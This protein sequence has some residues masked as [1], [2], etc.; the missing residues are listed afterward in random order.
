[1]NSLATPINTPRARLK[2]AKPFAILLAM[3]VRRSIAAIL[4]TLA[5]LLLAS[6]AGGPPSP[7]RKPGAQQSA[8]QAFASGNYEQA[9]R[10]WQRD[11]LSA[12]GAEAGS[13]R[14]SAADAWLLAGEEQ[15][16]R[17]NLRWVEKSALGP[18]DRARLNLVLADLALRA[19]HPEEAEALL[20]EASSTL[21]DSARMRYE[22]LSAATAQ[23]LAHP[24]ARDLR[25]AIALIEGSTA[26]QPEQ[27]VALLRA[28]ENVPSQELA[29]QANQEGANKETTGWLDLASVIRQNLVQ[30]EPL[31]DA[32]AA[33]KGRHAD[34]TLSENDAL[35][36]WLRYRQEFSPPLKVAVLLPG[37]G[38]FQP[39]GE[40]LRDGI[41][42]AYFDQPGGADITF[43][44]T[45]EE[46]E[47]TAAAYF[48]A[49]EQGAQW[50]I[51]P[52]QKES[53]DIL[54]NL[55]GLDTPVLALN[56]L[57]VDFVAPAGLAGQVLGISLSPEEEARAVA[58]EAMSAGLQRAIILAPE[59]EW[60]ERM[61]RNFEAE[62]LRENGR[63]VAASRYAETEND[64]STILQRLLKI[65]ESTARAQSVQNT[66]GAEVEFEP[67]RR[68]DVDV[69]F[70]AAN[71]TQGR[72]MRP[73]LRFHEA[74]DIPVYA[75][76]RVF[77]GKP[78][79]ASDQD[80]NGVNFPTTPYQL[81]PGNDDA[82]SRYSSLRGGTFTSLFALGRDA[83][84]L[85]PWLGLMKRDPDFH[86]PG[87]AG[88][89]R[90][91]PD[92]RL[93]REPQF[94]VFVGGAPTPLQRPKATE[95]EV[96]SEGR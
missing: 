79:R 76:G 69:I 75:T 62:F 21:P 55:A 85:L 42:S 80:L 5:T 65:D 78:D 20:K 87:A 51:G 37:G 25:E 58:R 35:D 1:M 68:N 82:S 72:L 63:I 92:N 73:Q 39:A 93:L 67:I 29:R 14:I 50:I 66:L 54:L 52:L 8:E 88:D 57:P 91:G 12:S 9:A 53:I 64:Y 41:M 43:H 36:L 70:L 49:R 38:R 6:C 18:A 48:E 24:G 95:T 83:W 46:G 10:L 86:F 7:D 30:P 90:N 84:N 27:A 81:Q 96:G 47:R 89:Y 61:A 59:S 16:A 11:A 74:G 31:T 45:G 94:A 40:A 44:S 22:Q 32:V 3:P 60:G 33:W 13:L 56:E 19:R 17:D 15:W 4:L 28:L 71:V 77:S 26:Y 34:H 2:K 23:M